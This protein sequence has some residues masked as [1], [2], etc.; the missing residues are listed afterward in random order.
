VL[1][2]EVESLHHAATAVCSSAVSDMT[3]DDNLRAA[4]SLG[5]GLKAPAIVEMPERVLMGK[6]GRDTTRL[7]FDRGG[8]RRRA[9]GGSWLLLIAAG[10]PSL[11]A[12]MVV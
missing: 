9:A 7:M 11:M 5:S 12:T 6:E 4:R 2:A 10:A 8:A 1:A 3:Y